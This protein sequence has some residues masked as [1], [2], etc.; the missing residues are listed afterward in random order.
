M[1]RPI[2]GPDR[3]MMLLQ[4]FQCRHVFC[5]YGASRPYT[6]GHGFGPYGRPVSVYPTTGQNNR[7]SANLVGLEATSNNSVQ[8]HYVP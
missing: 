6:L 2:G 3:L 5:Y 7:P 4:C 1:V 8:N